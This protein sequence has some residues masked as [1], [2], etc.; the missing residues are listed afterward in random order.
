M[1]AGAAGPR[2]ERDA[3]RHASEGSCSLALQQRLAFGKIY[4]RMRNDNGRWWRCRPAR[5]GAGKGRATRPGRPGRAPTRQRGPGARR[6]RS[7]PPRRARATQRAA[8]PG[9]PGRRR[10][11][12]HRLL[13]HADEAARGALAHRGEDRGLRH[14]GEV[15]RR[16]RRPPTPHVQPRGGGDPGRH[17]V[18]GCRPVPGAGVRHGDHEDGQ[19]PQQH[20]LVLPGQPPLRGNRTLG[21]LGRPAPA[22]LTPGS[23]P[24][25]TSSL[26]NGMGMIPVPWTKGRRAHLKERTCG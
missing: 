12:R 25:R 1:R 11:F 15:A 5:I 9:R 22:V 10:R 26:R 24:S 16:H 8:S 7:R 23:G 19:Q 21:Q 3:Q 20:C 14:L 13:L 4:N 6:R 2:R 18:P 17:G